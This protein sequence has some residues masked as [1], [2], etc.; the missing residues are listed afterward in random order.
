LFNIFAYRFCF[1]WL[2]SWNTNSMKIGI[3]FFF[4][5]GSFTMDYYWA[6]K[7]CSINIYWMTSNWKTLLTASL[8]PTQAQ[9]S[10]SHWLSDCNGTGPPPPAPRSQAETRVPITSWERRQGPSGHSPSHESAASPLSQSPSHYQRWSVVDWALD[11]VPTSI[12]WGHVSYV[13]CNS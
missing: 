11:Y 8:P 10:Q 13:L 2:L 12:V 4:W 7:R 6:P 9:D 3:F 5:S 1:S